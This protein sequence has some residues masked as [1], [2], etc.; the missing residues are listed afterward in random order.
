[1]TFHFNNQANSA[2]AWGLSLVEQQ[3]AQIQNCGTVPVKSVI[4]CAIDYQPS[5]K[6]AFDVRDSASDATKAFGLA[7]II[8]P[9]TILLLFFVIR[10]LI[11]GRFRLAKT[12]NG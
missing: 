3:H 5:I 10:W 4:D 11:T 1:M 7:T 9:L 8:T 12:A 2:F 6:D